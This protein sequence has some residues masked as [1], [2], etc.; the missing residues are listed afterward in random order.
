M[1]LK[2]VIKE[3]RR[4]ALDEVLSWRENDITFLP[5]FMELFPNFTNNFYR[6]HPNIS[7][8]SFMFCAYIFLHF[9]SKE[10]AECM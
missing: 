9:S 4:S 1:E 10:I 2:R 8:S 7:K 5:R 3:K 6:R